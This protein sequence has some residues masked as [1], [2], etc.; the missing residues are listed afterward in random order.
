[1]A[2]SKPEPGFSLGDTNPELAR[3]IRNVD[4]FTVKPFSNNKASWVCD[5]GHSW[6]SKISERSQGYGCPY[7]SN[8]K[9]LAGYNDLGTTVPELAAQAHGWDPST[10]TRGSKKLLD[11]KCPE[12]HIFS[13]S[14][15]D[16]NR[17]N[18]NL[19]PCPVCIGHQVLIGFNDLA[20]TH[21]ELAE[22]AN[23]WDPRTITR[24]STKRTSWKC[25]LGHTWITGTNVR[26]KGIGC[27]VCSNQMTLAG[28]ND[29]ATTHPE[30]ALQAHGWD[31]TTLVAGSNKKVNWQCALG[32][33]WVA[34]VSTRLR[35]SGC[36][37]CANKIVV[38]GFND[39]ATTHPDIASKAN[40]WDPTTITFGSDKK[41]MWLCQL[42]HVYSSSVNNQCSG[43]GCPYCSGHQ[44]LQGFND[45][46]TTHPLLA[47]QAVGWDTT[48]Y[49]SGSGKKMTWKCKLGHEYRAPIRNRSGGTGCPV[50]DNK[51]VA[52]GFND[53]ATT[54]PQLASE[55][56]GWDPATLV[57]GSNKKVDW[58]CAQGHEWNAVVSSRAS[59]GRGCPYCSG[60]LVIKGFN[61]FATINPN[62]LHEV[63]GWDPT[64]IAAFSDKKCA[65]IC[66]LGHKWKTSVKYRSI[67]RG[68]P[69]CAKSGYDPNR[70][71][72]LYFLRHD[73]FEM[74]Q[75]GIT[76]D[77]KRRLAKHR[78]GG[79]TEIELRG[80]MD[81]H[82]TKDLESS[83][84]F[85]IKRRGAVMANSQDVIRFDGWREA[86][87][88]DSLKAATIKE[89][90]EFVY[91]DE[92]K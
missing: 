59:G 17:A 81:G 87:T 64:E 23:G 36:P 66:E 72:W 82:L 76:N 16:R 10:V 63:N 4:P 18:Q 68:C 19:G 38:A 1:M 37:S 28:D 22:Q 40:G 53:L 7:C 31:P 88:S 42:G 24:N 50:C 26:V 69:S 33:V 15:K 29:L 73:E 62:L 75:I 48:T 30:I 54:H 11:W 60:N 44:C 12:G 14:P 79:W 56:N 43:Q 34:Q 84:L 55:A 35:G 51:E 61:D 6:E 57:F 52:V 92:S 80:P 77:P 27:A 21:P 90:L 89:L 74:F 91:A 49:T 78:S 71:A 9:V 20:T 83:I 13:S 25:S 70:D 86:W 3:Q 85:S 5:Q 39:L 41:K 46:A 32:H 47:A 2:Q 8:Q 45:L 65:F 67:G 58:K